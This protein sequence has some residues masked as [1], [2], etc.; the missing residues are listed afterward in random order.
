M[1]QP[2]ASQLPPSFE[3]K[4]QDYYT[5]QSK[6]WQKVEPFASKTMK[7]TAAHSSPNLKDTFR[8]L[9]WNI[10]VLIDYGKERMMAALKYLGQ[11]INKIPA[12]QPIVIF[13]QEM[14][15][16]DLRQIQETTWIQHRFHIT[17]LGAKSWQS[18]FYGT[19]TLVDK[20]ILIADVFR[21]PF[22]SRFER[23]GFFVDIQLAN[24]DKVLRLC[25][26]H[27]E[28]LISDPPI[29]PKQ[30]E[31]ASNYMHEENVYA[32]VL[33]G[34][35]NAIQPFDRMLHNAH[36][37]KDG[38]LALGGQEDCEEGY[39]WGQQVP[40]VLRE[41]FGC[42]RMDKVLYCGNIEVN[43][44]EKIGEGVMVEEE[45]VRKKMVES[46]MVEFVTDHIGL[47]AEVRVLGASL[48][49]SDFS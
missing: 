34:D 12:E 41:K 18:P 23:D 24:T 35:C 16:S 25:N 5:F 26:V 8:L 10:D 43:S 44:L 38:Y 11:L 21:A 2:L 30:L 7:E 1:A 3:P 45:E 22:P 31:Q 48:V 15:V 20:R 13:L 37:L 47:M 14:S 9:S 46:G 27:L 28:S 29:R 39:T 33:A 17:D 36:G 4:H 40:A 6:Q 19:T 42:S 49:V 32:A